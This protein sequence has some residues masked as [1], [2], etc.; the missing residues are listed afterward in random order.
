[1]SQRVSSC[2]SPSPKLDP[3]EACGSDSI[4]SNLYIKAYLKRGY[5]VYI[6]IIFHRLQ[7]SKSKD[8]LTKFICKAI[9]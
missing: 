4:Q 6:I 2:E 5:L 1:M 9:I 8:C 3:E 7:V